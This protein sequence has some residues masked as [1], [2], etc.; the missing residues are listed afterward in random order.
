M[1]RTIIVCS[2]SMLTACTFNVRS[3][4]TSVSSSTS[5][6]DGARVRAD[7]STVQSSFASPGVVIRGVD[8]RVASATVELSALLSGAETVDAVRDGVNVEWADATDGAVDL[9]VAYDGPLA[10]TVWVEGMTV[11]LPIGTVVELTGDDTAI[12]VAGL[13]A[14]ATV[15]S[16][17]GAI[18]VTQ[19][20][21]VDLAASSGAVDVEALRGELRTDSGAIDMAMA[22]HV[23]ATASS[24]AIR[25]T[26]GTG[27]RI[28]TSSGAIEI[29]IT[30]SLDRDLE[31]AADSGAIHLIV[32]P[33]FAAEL[34]IANTDGVVR[35]RA[36]GDSIEGHAWSGALNGGGPHTIRCTT[37]TGAITVEERAG[38]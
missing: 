30:G 4:S 16:D 10:E 12:D 33:G 24:G 32:P 28:V 11:D 20:R 21:V 38:A 26:V 5:L 6:D 9:R 1:V 17:S 34:D 36:G 8:G 31:L 29:E 23:V 35:V 22:E 7:V 13:D 27:G 37:Q 3:V 2:L 18:R 19:A 15:T 14:D 25:G